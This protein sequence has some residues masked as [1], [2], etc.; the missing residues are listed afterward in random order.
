MLNALSAI[1]TR[2]LSAVFRAV[3]NDVNG[4]FHALMGRKFIKKRI[5]NSYDMYLDLSDRGISRTLLLFGERELEHKRILELILKPGMSVLDIGCNIGYYALME[6]RLIG[7]EGTLIGVE[8]SPSNAQLAKRN[9]EL[10]GYGGVEVHNKAI[11]D[12]KGKKDLFMS[13]M[14]NLNT[15]HTQGTGGIHLDGT[16]STVETDTVPGIMA[17]RPL[18]LIRMDVEGHEVE[19]INGLLPAI[20]ADEMK[21]MIIFETHLSRYGDDHDMSEPLCRLFKAGYETRYVGSSSETGTKK[22][23]DRGYKPIETLRSDDVER[24]IF[25]N[26][27]DQ[28]TIDMICNTGGMRTVL[29]APR[30]V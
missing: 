1:R 24:G 11:S 5:Y 13:T 29:L 7:P 6:L 19:V 18:D 22:L 27:Q 23:V 2:G 30:S 12:N 4:R 17:G 15:F 20:E 26:I 14:S 8:P 16:V 21:P 28:D 25:E 3:S 10:N 9:L